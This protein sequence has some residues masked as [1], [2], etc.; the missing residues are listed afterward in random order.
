MG[1]SHLHVEADLSRPAIG[2]PV[3]SG[4]E[5]LPSIAETNHRVAIARSRVRSGDTHFKAGDIGVTKTASDF[6]VLG[7]RGQSHKNTTT[8][9]AELPLA[10][11]EIPGALRI[12]EEGGVSFKAAPARH[13]VHRAGP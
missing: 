12:E 9:V 6:D 3:E 10:R 8:V 13:E 5:K 4:S 2:S 7:L 11:V 1:G